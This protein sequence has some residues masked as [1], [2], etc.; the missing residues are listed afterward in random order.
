MKSYHLV[1]Q[2]LD[3]VAVT[4][5]GVIDYNAY[6]TATIQKAL[7]YAKKIGFHWGGDWTGG[8]VDHPHLENDIPYGSDTFNTKGQLP[9]DVKQ[10]PSPAPVTASS[11]IKAIGQIKIVGVSN[12][13]VIMDAPDRNNAKNV[14]TINL[15]ATIPISGSVV[16]KNNGSTGYYE[17]IYQNK[18]CYVS[19]QYGKKI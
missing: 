12:A 18:R 5:P 1:G 3:F 8:F 10:A 13:A 7:A 17:V 19:A 15:G 14:G 6:K 9:S 4:A 11:T 2:A 16:G